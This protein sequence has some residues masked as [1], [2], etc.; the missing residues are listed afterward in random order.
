MPP[1]GITH[2]SLTTLPSTD[3]PHRAASSR[4]R[5]TTHRGGATTIVPPRSSPPIRFVLDNMQS[6]IPHDLKNAVHCIAPRKAL[7]VPTQST[8]GAIAP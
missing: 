2:R 5:H 6:G 4:H 3:T 8:A 7:H 1:K